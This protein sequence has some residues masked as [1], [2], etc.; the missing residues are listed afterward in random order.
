MP[1]RLLAVVSALAGA[2]QRFS[3]Q[4]DRITVTVG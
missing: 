1:D 2:G 4:P 3:V